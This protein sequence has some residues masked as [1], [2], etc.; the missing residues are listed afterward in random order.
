MIKRISYLTKLHEA[1]NTDKVKVVFGVKRCGKST[2][3][4]QFIDELHVQRVEKAQIIYLNF[5]LPNFKQI[6]NT[7]Q[8][9]FQ[10][11]EKTLTDDQNYYVFLDELPQIGTIIFPLI[12][13]FTGDTILMTFK[14]CSS[15]RSGKV[16]W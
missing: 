15:E 8:E 11:L 10:T 5:E 6:L 3:I 12:E 14:T 7:E 4:N 2:L 13:K 1:K 16:P 9:W